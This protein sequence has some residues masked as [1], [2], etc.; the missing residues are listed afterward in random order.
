M[1]QKDGLKGPMAPVI[2]A[3]AA[4]GK[5]QT[6]MAANGQDAKAKL[7]LRPQDGISMNP[8]RVLADAKAR[9]LA[10]V[11]DYKP[12]PLPTFSL[13]GLA[14]KGAIRM[15]MD[16]EYLK[17]G[18]PAKD[19]VNHID[20]QAIDRLADVL[21]GGEKLERD[22]VAAHVAKNAGEI[23][24]LIAEKGKGSL[25]VNRGIE[26]NY[27]R[28]M[29]LER[30]RILNAF[31]DSANVWPRVRH[32]IKTNQYLREKYPEN[33]PSPHKLRET[34]DMSP[35][36]RRDIDGKPL[37][38]QDEKNLRRMAKMIAGL[39]KFVPKG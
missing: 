5:P 8:D 32:T 22:D 13:P 24:N 14:G 35:L 19:G 10:M 3:A 38:G 18:D 33:P 39:Y 2:Q 31:G 36:P 9:A 15:N 12:K 21:T 27:N 16:K 11:P 26:L 7:W 37:S 1:E 29:Q 28:M 20:V 30:D 4:L 23:G 34:M 17:A 25:G 6:S